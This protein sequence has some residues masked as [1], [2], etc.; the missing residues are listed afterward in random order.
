[1]RWAQALVE[2]FAQH[3][4]TAQIGDVNAEGDLHVIQG[5]HYAYEQWRHARPLM[6]DRAYYGPVDD[7]VSLGWLNPDG[8][9]DFGDGGPERW[10]AH[11]AAGLVSLDPMAQGQRYVL[12]GDFAED[13]VAYQRIFAE[14][15]ARG[16]PIAYRPHPAAPDWPD[17]PAW[18]LRQ[19]FDDV[20]EFTRLA[21]GFRTTSLV[22]AALAGVPVCC[23]DPRNPVYPI[24]AHQLTG[25]GV[26]AREAWAHSLAWKQWHIDEIRRG[27]FWPTL[28]GVHHAPD[29]SEYALGPLTTT[30]TADAH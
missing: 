11:V 12:F 16:W 14:A 24:A 6:I 5:P 10:E 26:T 15:W 29:A 28:T 20:I 4:L 1:M 27:T 3:G 21:I 2:G 30:R 18:V 13:R 19:P 17:C 22:T 9:R 8:S 23:L 25:R 7:W